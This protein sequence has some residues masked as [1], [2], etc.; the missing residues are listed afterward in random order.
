MPKDRLKLLTLVL[1]LSVAPVTAAYCGSSRLTAA[2]ASKPHV[3]SSCPRHNAREEGSAVRAH[4]STPS[5]ITLTDRIPPDSLFGLG[6]GAGM[7][8]P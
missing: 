8:T 4:A 1:I 6:R 3:R 7:V 5:T 2:T